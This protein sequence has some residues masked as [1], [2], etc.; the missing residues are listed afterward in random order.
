MGTRGFFG[1]EKG[2]VLKVGYNQFDSHPDSKGAAFMELLSEKT[3]QELDGMFENLVLLKASDA[4]RKDEAYPGQC[5]EILEKILAYREAAEGPHLEDFSENVGRVDRWLEE[6]GPFADKLLKAGSIKGLG[7]S[8]E[9]F[10]NDVYA[11]GGDRSPKCAW[12]DGYPVMFDGSG[13]CSERWYEYGYVYNCGS[14][15]VEI[16]GSGSPCLG[17]AKRIGNYQVCLEVDL[18][19]VRCAGRMG[20]AME[21]YF[22][23]L[24]AAFDEKYGYGADR[25]GEPGSGLFLSVREA[26]ALEKL[27]AKAGREPRCKAM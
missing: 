27:A 22:R 10:L 2:G 5:K 15:K 18:E 16:Y 25:E 13:S 24:Y 9:E 17:D 7:K 19:E 20:I 21:D 6:N 4:D 8:Y 23:S 14:G 1:F 26:L 12:A 11:M 3:A